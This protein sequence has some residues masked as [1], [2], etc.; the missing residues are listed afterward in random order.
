MPAN[1]RPVYEQVA[2]V[3]DDYAT[4]RGKNRDELSIS[5]CGIINEIAPASDESLYCCLLPDLCDA[6]CCNPLT[7][8][9][10]ATKFH[11]FLPTTV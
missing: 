10:V 11:V 6:C 7:A 3:S 2:P 9:R 1:R 4:I 8:G 5:V